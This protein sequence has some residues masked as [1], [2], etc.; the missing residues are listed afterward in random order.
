MIKLTDLKQLQWALKMHGVRSYALRSA[1]S[2]SKITMTLPSIDLIKQ[3][4]ARAPSFDVVHR[5]FHVFIP[6]RALFFEISN[7]QPAE[8]NRAR[9]VANFLFELFLKNNCKKMRELC[10][11]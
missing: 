5:T 3:T 1:G 7:W 4:G 10:L 11:N 8:I 9:G 2:D 6:S